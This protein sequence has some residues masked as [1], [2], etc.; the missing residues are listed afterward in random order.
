MQNVFLEMT[1]YNCEI[2]VSTPTAHPHPTTLKNKS[3]QKE[4]WKLT[5]DHVCTKKHDTLWKMI[6]TL[7][8]ECVFVLRY[9]IALK[10]LRIKTNVSPLLMLVSNIS[11]S[12]RK[13]MNTKYFY[14][15]NYFRPGWQ[16][17]CVIVRPVKC[18]LLHKMLFSIETWCIYLWLF[19]CIKYQNLNNIAALYA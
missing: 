10:V 4:Q 14:E 9:M 6:L 15:I 17:F 2:N 1:K 11:L 18:Q 12:I 13:D 16:S 7:I 19:I 3:F 8:S 5:L